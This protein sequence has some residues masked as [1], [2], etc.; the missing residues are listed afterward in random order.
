MRRVNKSLRIKA[1]FEILCLKRIIAKIEPNVP[2]RKVMI[3]NVDSEILV[4]F[5]MAFNLSIANN[6]KPKTE[7]TER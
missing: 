1:R 6:R 5:F 3:S 2:P 7:K 4:L